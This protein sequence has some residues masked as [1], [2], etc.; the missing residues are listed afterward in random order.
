MLRI[1][2]HLL[3]S[4]VG[5]KFPAEQQL[6]YMLNGYNHTHKITVLICPR[7]RVVLNQIEKNN[8]KKFYLRKA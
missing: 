8:K 3:C 1:F 2:A 5:H 7:C 6:A 4:I